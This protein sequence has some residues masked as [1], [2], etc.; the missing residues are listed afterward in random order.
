[1]KTVVPK[2]G[3]AV[4]E[5]LRVGGLVAL[6]LVAALFLFGEL[7][8][9]QK[10]LFPPVDGSP[11]YQRDH[12]RQTIQA[13]WG[14]W[15]HDALG[16]GF[17]GASL[18]PATLLSMLLPPL[19]FHLFRYVFGTVLLGLATA[20]FLKGRG[21]RGASQWLPAVGMALSGY[22]FTLISAGHAGYFDMAPFAVL[23]F[24][25]VD[26]AFR[27]RSRYW[28]C[29]AGVC[30]AFGIARQPDIMALFGLLA[31]CFSVFLLVENRP[32]NG[33][34]ADWLRYTG[35]L[36]GGGLLAT[37]LFAALAV[38]S[39]AFASRALETREEVRG[40]TSQAQWEYATNW[41]MPPE[42]LLDMVAPFVYGI[43]TGDSAG[44]YWG[45]LGR[46]LRWGET[47]QGLMNLK[48]HTLYM[49]LIPLIFGLYAFVWTFRRKRYSD[50]GDPDEA[51]LNHDGSQREILF[52]AGA[53]VLTVILAMGRY[54]PFYRLVYAWPLFS[55]IR[56]PVK[57]IHLSEWSLAVLF[58][59]GLAIF[60]RDV[61]RVFGGQDKV[62]GSK[63][64]RC[65]SET[66]IEHRAMLN[67]GEHGTHGK[68][69]RKSACGSGKVVKRGNAERA[70][71][72]RW[73]LGFGIGCAALGIVFLLAA[74]IVPG[75]EPLRTYWKD[76]GFAQHV[77]LLARTM[78]GGLLRAT[79]LSFVAAGVFVL[80]MYSRKAVVGAVVGVL[81]VAV[82]ADMA[83][84]GKRYVR[85]GD[86]SPWY[87]R[88][89]VAERILADPEPSRTA[90][91]LGQT[92]WRNW[93]FGSLAHHNVDILQPTL[94]D[95]APPLEYQRFFH[96]LQRDPLRLW[97]ITNTRYILGARQQFAPLI[98]HP[99]IEEVMAFE[100]DVNR[101]VP[102]GSG[103]TY[104]LL[105]F[106]AAMPRASLVGDWEYAEPDAALKKIADPQWNPR[107][108]AW[109]STS[110]PSPDPS[111]TS[112]GT[113]HIMRYGRTRMDVAVET[114]APALLLLND[115]YDPDW[116]V[117]VNG[118]KT[119]LVRCNYIMRGVMVPAGES[120]VRFTYRP[121]LPWLLL[122][123]AG[124]MTMVFWSGSRLVR[125]KTVNE[126]ELDP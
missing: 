87:N 125:R 22:T 121:N 74:G 51:F 39:F 126:R 59:Y 104:M 2:D 7:L 108:K 53:F 1:M 12:Q 96:A 61:G 73:L 83:T 23:M 9:S 107:Q 41:S 38:S 52:W 6:C 19:V 68:N 77:D 40:K 75:F 97:A 102:V 88:N 90:F 27:E 10:Y 99:A 110:V 100:L 92:T 81:W 116:R 21:F 103:G 70:V 24:G 43:E 32:K 95:L 84:V 114:S 54:T 31:L 79:A 89:P 4:A 13:L 33:E 17:G 45:R 71:V 26:R 64:M 80:P 55:K 111:E 109:V 42:E 67:H 28:F 78:R 46:S 49:G 57:F 115:K 8:F 44:P 47:R 3:Q 11:F 65:R 101:Y 105:E 29:W 123:L 50:G 36:C 118:E 72:H 30:G 106:K 5:R 94:G 98:G 56:A 122:S 82:L 62:A 58:A 66:D 16:M 86:V 20:F 76:L 15:S 35:F 48:Q 120:R 113:A 124:I 37:A 69:A 91:Y 112:A 63:I 14:R 117:T 34:R 18:V 119:D 93:S 25:C 60:L 85:V